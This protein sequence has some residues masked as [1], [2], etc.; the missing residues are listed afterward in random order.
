MGAAHSADPVLGIE[1]GAEA[2]SCRVDQ[3]VE[4]VVE[5]PQHQQADPIPGVLAS[6][7]GAHRAPDASFFPNAR[8]IRLPPGDVIFG[9]RELLWQHTDWRGRGGGSGGGRAK[10]GGGEGLCIFT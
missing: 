5:R 10:R 7:Q 2:L 4:E 1:L 9:Y 3:D 8:T 6:G